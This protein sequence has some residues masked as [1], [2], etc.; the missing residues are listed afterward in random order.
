MSS[1][2]VSTRYSY[3]ALIVLTALNLI[4]YLDRFIFSALVPYIKLD[5]GYTDAQ[6]GYLGSAFTFVYTICSPLFGMLGDRYRRGRLIALGV[7]IWSA[8]T[9]MG[10]LTRGF[11]HL[12]ISRTLVGIGEADYATIGPSLLSDFFSKARRGMVMSIMFA[13]IPVGSA[14]GYFLGGYLGHPN[15]FGW[16][17]AL[18]IVGLPGILTALFA[19]FMYE[20]ERGVMDNE[21]NEVKEKYKLID[22]YKV[23]LKNKGYVL[24]CLGYAAVTFALGALVFW[25]PAWL[26]ED[27]GISIEL[28]SNILGGCA[29]IGGFIGTLGGGLISDVLTKRIKGAYLWVCSISCLL[30]AV[31]TLIA[32]ISHNKYVYIPSVFIGITLIFLGNGPVNA[33]VVN[34]IPASVRSTAIG[35]VVVFIHVFGDGISVMLVGEISTTLKTMTNSMPPFLTTIG[36]IFNLQAGHQTLSM[37]MLLMP[38]AMVVGSILYYMALRTKE[39]QET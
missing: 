36:N 5:T 8:A 4:N 27:K 6:M 31:P 14:I 15:I 10:G 19:Y 16:R 9:A 26:S 24:T 17:H 33:V 35:L 25:A 30:A 18:L 22:A 3:Y 32:I 12:L 20:P 34:L 21:E 2:K 11:T 37:G 38:V 1:Q 13:T 28:A 7:A 23:I 39:G 29:L